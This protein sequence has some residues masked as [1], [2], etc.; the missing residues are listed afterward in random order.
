MGVEVLKDTAGVELPPAA[1]KTIHLEG[2]IVKDGVRMTVKD[3]QLTLDELSKQSANFAS[4]PIS[5]SA[6]V[7]AL[8]KAIVRTGEPLVDVTT[9]STEWR[10]HPRPGKMCRSPGTS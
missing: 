2:R 10:G 3:R 4:S 7:Q 9:F 8:N 1:R 5:R 6:A